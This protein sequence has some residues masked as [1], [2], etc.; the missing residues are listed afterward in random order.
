MSF[1]SGTERLYCQDYAKNTNNNT[2]NN[3]KLA[4]NNHHLQQNAF[5]MIR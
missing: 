4:F 5:C 3:K 1:M 2:T